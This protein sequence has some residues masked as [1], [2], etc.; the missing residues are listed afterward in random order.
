[1]LQDI[2]FLVDRAP[3]NRGFLAK[4]IGD[5]SAKGFRTI[6]DHKHRTSC[7]KSSLDQLFQEPFGNGRC[8]CRSLAKTQNVFFPFRV[9][10]QCNHDR[11]TPDIHTIQHQNNQI[12]LSKR[13]GEEFFHALHN[14]IDDQEI[15][16]LQSHGVSCY[17]NAVTESFFH[18]LKTECVCFEQYQ[19]REDGHRSLFDYIEVFYNR[20]RR[21]SSLGYRT[22]S[23]AEESF[24]EA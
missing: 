2:P 11:M 20:Q 24:T 4:D 9:N 5:G 18:T 6:D 7:R 17:D 1:M 10:A 13:T 23:E 12:Q 14:L 19:S 16:I 8:L 21:H 22:P 15:L 3:L